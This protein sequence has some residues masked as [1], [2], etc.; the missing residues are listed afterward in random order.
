[1]TTA[2]F[3]KAI[4]DIALNLKNPAICDNIKDEY[5]RTM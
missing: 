4:F 5:D 2:T 3:T 1:M